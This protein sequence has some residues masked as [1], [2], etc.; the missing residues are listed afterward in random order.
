M[1]VAW[2]YA[3]LFER[4]RQLLMLYSVLQRNHW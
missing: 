3:L 1:P 4:S 2:R